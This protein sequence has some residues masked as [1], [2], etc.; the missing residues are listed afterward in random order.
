MR[1]R[2]YNRAVCEDFLRI[3][4]RK[5]SFHSTGPEWQ[6]VPIA[7]SVTADGVRFSHNGLDYLVQIV[8]TRCN[9]GGTRPWFLC[10]TCG[11]RRAVLYARLAS[12]RFG[13]RRCLKL[14][15]LAECEDAFGRAILKL[16]RVERRICESTAGTVGTAPLANKPRGQHWRTFDRRIAGLVNIRAALCRVWRD[17]QARS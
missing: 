5:L 16:R 15:Y 2:R 7:V 12:E 3:D 10:P 13:C 14:L 4:V 8:R 17:A 1:N 9:Y 6:Y 11:D